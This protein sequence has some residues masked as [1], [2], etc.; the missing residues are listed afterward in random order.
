VERRGRR[1]RARR[2]PTRCPNGDPGSAGTCPWPDD[3][4]GRGRGL[5]APGPRSP[6]GCAS[7]VTP[8]RAI[9]GCGSPDVPWA[10]GGLRPV[11]RSGTRTVGTRTSARWS[12]AGGADRVG[13]PCEPRPLEPHVSP[14]P[15][16]LTGAPVFSGESARLPVGSAL[17]STTLRLERPGLHRGSR[18]GPGRTGAS[19]GARVSVSWRPSAAPIGAPCRCPGRRAGPWTGSSG[20]PTRRCRCR[21][22]R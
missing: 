13:C 1:R 7:C 19:V 18:L 16:H 14:R 5:S 4:G 17:P 15:P 8:P 3:R 22:T 2:A 10:C 6:A 21:G 11:R 9:L 20:G 12:P